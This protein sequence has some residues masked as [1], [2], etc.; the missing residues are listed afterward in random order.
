[1]QS[2][3]DHETLGLMDTPAR[4]LLED[5][6]ARLSGLYGDRLV[7]LVL[8]GSYARGTARK[9]SDVDVAMVLDGAQRPWLEIDRTGSV[10]AELSLKY[11]VPIS[12]V[13]VRQQDWDQD[14]TLL[15]RSLHREGILVG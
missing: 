1:M 2:L 11:G 6:K 12:L 10:V 14:R 3:S 13:P 5:L 7:G 9:G 8:Y 15:A 4:S